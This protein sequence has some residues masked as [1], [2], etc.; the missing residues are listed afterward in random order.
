MGPTVFKKVLVKGRSSSIECGYPSR[1]ATFETL[2]IGEISQKAGLVKGSSRYSFRMS[3][4]SKSTPSRT[5]KLPL[6][7]L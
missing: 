2:F 6:I 7:L 3:E 4:I 1:M 5:T